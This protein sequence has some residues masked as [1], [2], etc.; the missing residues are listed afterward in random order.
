MS[1]LIWVGNTLLP[2]G[3]VIFAPIAVLLSVVCAIV[4]YRLI[5]SRLSSKEL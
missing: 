3:V 1:D 2:R 4:V 5:A